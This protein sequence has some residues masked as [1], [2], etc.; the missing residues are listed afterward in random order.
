MSNSSKI[1]SYA[2]MLSTKRGAGEDGKIILRVE[3]NVD[4]IIV[5]KN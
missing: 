2:R 5:E 4:I 1:L 3:L